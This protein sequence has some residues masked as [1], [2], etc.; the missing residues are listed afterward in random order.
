MDVTSLFFVDA[1]GLHVADYPT[2]LAFVQAGFQNIYGADIYLESDSQDGQ[3]AA[4]FA[5]ALFDTA[6]A[7]ASSINSFSP[8]TAQ[9]ASLS[10]QV[11]INGLSRQVPSNSTADLTIVGVAGTIILAGIAQDTL[12]QKWDLPASVTIPSGGSIVVTATAEIVGAITAD[13]ATITSIFTPTRGWQ[14]VNNVAAA[15]PGAPVETDAQLRIRQG[16]ST[17]LP[18]LTVIDATLGALENLSGVQ[19]VAPYE[20]AT[21]T[22]DGNGAPP[23]NV[24]FVV[25][26]G[27][28]VQIATAIMLK[29]TPGVPTYGTTP[30]SITDPKGMPITINFFRPITATISVVV[31]VGTLA[32]WSSDF[33]PLIQAAVA[34]YLNA[35]PIGAT[36]FQSQLFS[37][38]YLLG[39]P[40]GATYN[41]TSITIQKNSGSPVTTSIPLAFDENPVCVAGTNVT[42][43][44]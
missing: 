38:A 15:T 23:F 14:T 42:V 10:R 21:N 28:S 18:A 41:I 27:D 25:L 44:T 31:T 26:G 6:S 17:S 39:L 36:V 24:Y 30:E 12:G 37:Q 2:F 11:K 7:S 40:A 9:G 1:A 22:T 8:V 34:A 32:G 16:T 19:K 20:N 4:F 5:Q 35:L 33:I 43:N 3:L 29:K 13:A